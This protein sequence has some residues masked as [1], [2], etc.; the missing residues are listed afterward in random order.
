MNTGINKCTL[1]GK[2]IEVGNSYCE[3]CTIE[4]EI[5]EIVMKLEM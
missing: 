2:T 3:D 1:C 4:L 5:N